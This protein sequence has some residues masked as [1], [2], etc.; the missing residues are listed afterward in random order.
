VLLSRR[1]TKA[2]PLRPRL[3][4]ALPCGTCRSL[5]ASL[6]LSPS[7]ERHVGNAVTLSE[8]V[9]EVAGLAIS[10]PSLQ[11]SMADGGSLVNECEGSGSRSW[12]E[13]WSLA[14]ILE[15]S[16]RFTMSGSR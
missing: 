14:A 13:Q 3:R 15:V 9:F 12:S 5:R 1:L 11:Q 4:A 2:Y 8:I 16:H 7:L 6:A 10:L